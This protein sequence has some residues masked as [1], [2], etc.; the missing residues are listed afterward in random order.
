MKK[1]R[2]TTARS[3]CIRLRNCLKESRE[4]LTGIRFTVEDFNGTYSRLV[5]EGQLLASGFKVGCHSRRS[6][7]EVLSAP[8]GRDCCV[9]M[10]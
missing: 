1:K 4:T 7:S 9:N 10:K 6:M 2:V 3:S 8:I 5:S